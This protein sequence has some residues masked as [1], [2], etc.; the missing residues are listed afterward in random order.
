M[1]NS[2]HT[3]RI[4]GN[5]INPDDV[6]NSFRNEQADT[7]T[8]WV[9]R[10]LALLTAIGMGAAMMIASFF[11]FMLSLAVLPLLAV[12]AWAFKRKLEKDLARADEPSSAQA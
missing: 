6:I 4:D 1:I 12:S 11:L 9:V 5:D 10:P 3:I 8:R 2:T 7:F